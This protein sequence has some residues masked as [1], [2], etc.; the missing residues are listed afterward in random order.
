MFDETTDDDTQHCLELQMQHPRNKRLVL[1]QPP[2][3]WQTLEEIERQI[4]ED[5]QNARSAAALMLK[6]KC[7]LHLRQENDAK[8]A[9]KVTKADG[10]AS[11]SVTVIEAFKFLLEFNFD[12]VRSETHVKRWSLCI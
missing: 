10:C 12:T 9:L 7:L 8:K 11:V 5:V 6:R 4:L 3:E 2:A 1:S